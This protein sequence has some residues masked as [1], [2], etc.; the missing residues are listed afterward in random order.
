MASGRH[1]HSGV[2]ILGT[3]LWGCSQGREPDREKEVP[4]EWWLLEAGGRRGA[5]ASAW[6]GN[7]V[8]NPKRPAGES[9][10]SLSTLT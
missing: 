8:G 4:W 2:L 7:L 10:F 9:H 5:G 1:A 3:H 6:C